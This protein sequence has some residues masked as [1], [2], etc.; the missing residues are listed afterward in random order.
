MQ[1][2]LSSKSYPL[3]YVIWSNELDTTG[4]C[5]LHLPTTGHDIQLHLNIH[6]Q[7]LEWTPPDLTGRYT[8]QPVGTEVIFSTTI[9]DGSKVS[10]IKLSPICLRNHLLHSYINYLSQ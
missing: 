9:V 3:Y 1:V 8:C 4:S 10:K 5:R 6:L 2:P 7:S